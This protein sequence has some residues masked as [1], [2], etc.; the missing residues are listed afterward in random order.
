MYALCTVASTCN[1]F[2][3]LCVYN[4]SDVFIILDRVHWCRILLLIETWI[5]NLT[6]APTIYI[7]CIF[8]HKMMIFYCIWCHMLCFCMTYISQNVSW[9]GNVRHGSWNKDEITDGIRDRLKPCPGGLLPQTYDAE[10]YTLYI[11]TLPL[12]PDERNGFYKK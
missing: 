2:A 4:A 5:N 12:Q 6:R 9:F 8:M 7:S 10:Y 3:H 1:V 11:S